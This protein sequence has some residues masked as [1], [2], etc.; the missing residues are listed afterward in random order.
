MTTEETA[1]VVRIS[2]ND[3]PP[4]RVPEFC[5]GRWEMHL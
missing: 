1:S 5:S 4:N 3:V 2:A